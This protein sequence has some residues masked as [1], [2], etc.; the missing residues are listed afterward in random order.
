MIKKTVLLFLICL[1]SFV[2]PLVIR[3]EETVDNLSDQ[4]KEY[5]QK[6]DELG[7][8]KDTLANQVKIL[9]SQVELTILKITQTENSIKSLENEINNLT[10]E[11]SKL[12]IQL[13]ELSSLYVLQIIENYKL[14]KKVP[15][16]TFLFSS[17][18]NNFLEQHKYISNIQKSS[19]NSLINMETVRTNYDLQKT[20]KV[21]KQQ[22]LETLQKTLATQKNNL[23]NQKQNKIYL[24]ETTK[25]DEK[26]YQSLKQAAES[27]LNSLLTA[28]F[29]GKR[30]V[31]KGEAIGLMGNTGYSF[32]A[33]LHFGLYN[34]KESEVSSF[35]YENDIDPISYLSQ[36]QWPMS[37]YEITQGRGQT[38]Y[39]YLYSDRFHHGIDL[40]SANKIVYAVNDGM[41]Y[42]YQDAYPNQRKGSGN[43]VKLFHSDGKMSLYLHL[44]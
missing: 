43:H 23:A 31:K 11:I 32:G 27:E 14:Q 12:D 20:A 29:T 13:N 7:K 33:H 44:Q 2:S 28:K 24:L 41:A 8:A 25:N 40:V 5:T 37:N 4:I 36:Y 16:F 3:S 1:F 26:K 21:K 10:V 19:Q 39:A 38:K 18:L 42:F 35:V 22:E 9:N 17:K 15:A 34:L 30:A 6:L